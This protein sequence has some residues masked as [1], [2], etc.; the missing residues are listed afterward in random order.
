MSTANLLRDDPF[1]RF[2]FR[3]EFDNVVQQLFASAQ[4]YYTEGLGKAVLTQ[5][6][7]SFSKIGGKLAFSGGVVAL[8]DLEIMTQGQP[9]DSNGLRRMAG[10]ALFAKINITGA[11][12]I[13]IMAWMRNNRLTGY[14]FNQYHHYVDTDRWAVIETLD[15]GT[16]LNTAE[17]YPYFDVDFNTEYQYCSVLRYTGALHLIKGG[18][19]TNWTTYWISRFGSYKRLC[20]GINPLGSP[21]TVDD[22]YVVD[23]PIPWRGNDYPTILFHQRRSIP[24]GLTFTHT[25]DCFIDLMVDAL[26]SGGNFIDIEFRK[27]DANNFWR[28]RLDSGGTIALYEVVA[29]VPTLR[30]TPGFF[31]SLGRLLIWTAGTNIV[32]HV[33]NTTNP[34]YA[35][36]VNFQTETAGRILVG[37][38]G[39]V[40]DLQVFPRFPSAIYTD[41]L[42]KVDLL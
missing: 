18:A 42:D 32:S 14:G 2:I 4:S 19:F 3:A 21:G 29:G 38:G 7:G 8:G 5:N 23:L 35:A 36:A 26:P 33:N 31:F 39:A 28:A 41:E 1:P 6:N 9:H 22:L 24:N 25:A 40:S 17:L 37:V 12:A 27:Q 20:A 34:A 13:N 30:G 15:D 10:R 11:G 16:I